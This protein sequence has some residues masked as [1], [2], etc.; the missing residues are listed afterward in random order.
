MNMETEAVSSLPTSDER[1]MAALA[2]FL[3][4]IVALIVWAIQKDKSRFVRFQALQAL[5]FDALVVA[6]SLLLSFC[7]V[8]VVFAGIFVLLFGV[9]NDPASAEDFQYFFLFPSMMPFGIFILVLPFSL[10]IFV[11]RLIATLSVLSGRNFRYPILGR[12][13][14]AFSQLP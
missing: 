14:E 4:A 5:A 7:T 1:L 3:G 6:F 9:T 12:K 13:V 10:T 8:A 2:H 11:I